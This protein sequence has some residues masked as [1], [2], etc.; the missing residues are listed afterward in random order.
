M[1]GDKLN[2]ACNEKKKQIGIAKSELNEKLA[3]EE[4]LVTEFKALKRSLS[5]QKLSMT[6]R[7]ELL[8]KLSETKGILLTKKVNIREINEI[9][10]DKEIM[11]SNLIQRKF[12]SLDK[13]NNMIHN[14]SS[15]LNMQGLP[16]SSF[17]ASLF[18]IK[19]LSK[20]ADVDEQ[21]NLLSEALKKL[22]LE[23][24]NVRISK[25]SFCTYL[26]VFKLF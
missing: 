9:G 5:N 16:K 23:Y 2:A 22:S 1:K 24:K 4:S 19:P 25:L 10:S 14:V 17:R 3:A 8:Q 6:K 15:E 11:L 12:A 20:D 7:N 26:I 18:E 13:L 21:L